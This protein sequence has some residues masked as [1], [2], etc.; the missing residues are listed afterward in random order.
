MLK[1]MLNTIIAILMAL[2]ASLSLSSAQ[3]PD[4]AY[5][6]ETFSTN[7]SPSVDV[8]TSGGSI[9]VIGHSDNEVRVEMYVRRNNRYYFPNDTDL[10]DFEIEISQSGNSVTA[11]ARSHRT[12][13]RNWF[14]GNHFSI[15][16]VVYAPVNSVVD[17]QTS[18]G[19][20]SG[21]N[22]SNSVNLQTSGGSVNVESIEGEANLR[23][24]GGSI[25]ITNG[26]GNMDART[27]GGSIRVNNFMGNLD[28][29]TS[30]GSLNISDSGG[31]ISGR[32]SGGSIRAD[33]VEVT[34]DISLRTSG[35]GITINVP[36]GNGY[37]LDLKGQ[38]VN[39]EL[40]NFSGSAERDQIAGRMNGGGYTIDAHTS[41]GS[42]NVRFH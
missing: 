35:G 38:R 19:S 4:D 30:G 22:L 5:R 11:S 9:N 10:E 21:Q 3:S 28:I 20:I 8:R 15:S 1:K 12:G 34:G 16:F 17:G 31:A 29:R 39:I 33:F 40:E 25:T 6:V 14:G 13:V 36:R 37:D 26:S 2:F 23:T 41:G 32:T 27:S 24:S 42:V 7:R 18:G